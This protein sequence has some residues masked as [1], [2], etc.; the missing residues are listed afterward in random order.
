MS[1]LWYVGVFIALTIVDIVLGT[2]SDEAGYGLLGTLFLLAI[3]V[4]TLS[5]GSRRLHDTGRSGWWQLLSIAPFG[6]IALM[7][8][9]AT[10][11]EEGA[12]EY[13]EDPA[14]PATTTDEMLMAE[15]VRATF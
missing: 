7:V 4:P 15:K 11:G 8:M 3:V 13:G 9:C 5:V 14:A 12:N 1:F 6:F 2:F 10:K